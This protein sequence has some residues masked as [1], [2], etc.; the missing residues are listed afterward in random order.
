MKTFVLDIQKMSTED[1]PGIRTTVFLKGCNLQCAWCHNPESIEFCQ[2][3]YWLK[4]AC[5][6]CLTCVQECH[7]HA[8]SATEQGIRIDAS[9]CDMCQRCKEQCPTN[10]IE[11]K[12][13]EM[14]ADE[15]VKE[16]L[17]DRAYYDSSGGGVTFSG[18]DPVLHTQFL[19]PILAQLK[20]SGI[21]IA[22]DTAGNYPYSLLEKL[23]PYIDL[24]LYDIK[25]IDSDAHQMHTGVKND[26]VLNNAAKLG[27]LT[28]P[29]VWVRT[30]II[31]NAT[32]SEQNIAG[33]GEFIGQNMANI[34][35][36]E[37]VS[38]NNLATQ[39]YELLEKTWQYKGDSLIT[40]SKMDSLCSTAKK[41]SNKAMWSGATKLE[42]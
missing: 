16:V 35:K 22:L 36:W 42:V 12:G 30:P 40:K 26:L 29:K 37:L 13:S 4:D 27:A 19:L 31:P 18:G 28:Y 33:I 5:I 11:I 9:L 6:G 20:E 23:L 2:N 32:D 1:G 7:T 24:V 3:I 38:F 17:K 8:I 25:H 14:C 41:Y 21:H 34:E 39:K 10:S 15:I